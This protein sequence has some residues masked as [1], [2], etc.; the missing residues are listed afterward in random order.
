MQINRYLTYLILTQIQETGVQCAAF[1]R[2]I[3]ASRL[4]NRPDLYR[5]DGCA[6]TTERLPDYS[7]ATVLG[8]F[9]SAIMRFVNRFVCEINLETPLLPC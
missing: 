6:L 3:S 1:G 4:H 5:R 7:T 2:D 9:I 8:M